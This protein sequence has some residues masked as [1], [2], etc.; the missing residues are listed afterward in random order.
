MFLSAKS[1]DFQN[2]KYKYTVPKSR[3]RLAEKREEKHMQLQSVTRCVSRLCN[4]CFWSVVYSI[5]GLS[6]N[7][8]ENFVI[9]LGL[10]IWK[11]VV[12]ILLERSGAKHAF[13][14]RT[15]YLHRR[16]KVRRHNDIAVLN[17]IIHWK[18]WNIENVQNMG[19]KIK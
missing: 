1:R 4:Y 12:T 6:M 18:T 15:N 8:M 14:Q 11:S 9:V 5:I 19:G 17:K 16:M 7:V 3:T 10:T 2:Q 13:H